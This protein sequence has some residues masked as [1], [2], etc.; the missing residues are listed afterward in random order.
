MKITVKFYC[1]NKF[2]KIIIPEVCRMVMKSVA[3]NEKTGKMMYSTKKLFNKIF[4][5]TAKSTP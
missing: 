1:F 3:W 2:V 5:I 4:C